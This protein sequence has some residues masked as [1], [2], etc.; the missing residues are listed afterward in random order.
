[1]CKKYTLIMALVANVLFITAIN[2]YFIAEQGF[3]WHVLSFFG[4][5]VLAGYALTSQT[6]KVMVLAFFSVFIIFNLGYYELNK[7]MQTMVG[8]SFH[9]YPELF[10]DAP[11]SFL[12]QAFKET[13]LN[14]IS[15][16]GLLLL[17]INVFLMVKR[18]S[19]LLTLP[20]FL[21]RPRALETTLV[22]LGLG[23]WLIFFPNVKNT[24]NVFY[25][26]KDT[27]PVETNSTYGRIIEKFMQA[28]KQSAMIKANYIRIREGIGYFNVF[29]LEDKLVYYSTTGDQVD[30]K[31]RFFVLLHPKNIKDIP[32]KRQEYKFDNIS[33]AF[34]DHGIQYK[35][36]G[37][38]EKILPKYE[39]VKYRT[40][41]WNKEE[42]KDLW[43]AKFE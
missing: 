33:F 40:G 19:P 41:Q 38:T 31:Y 12:Q 16:W 37:Y 1:M 2:E 36:L 20:D 4:F 22:S 3:W 15:Y 6:R 17:P 34:K 24:V 29:K 26:H 42:K 43:S 25:V 18:Q 5:V 35:N 11:T 39:V 9:L 21:T 28:Q 7:T 10:F 27:L 14:W 30:M 13:A 23:A 8:T 32:E